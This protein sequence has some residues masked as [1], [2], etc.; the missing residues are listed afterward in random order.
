[1]L[2]GYLL[3]MLAAIGYG[4]LPI[5]VKW[6][7]NL[8]LTMD[9]MLFS[10]FFI[11]SSIMTF[12]LL[13][14]RKKG[15]KRSKSGYFLL[16]LQGLLFFGSSYTYFLSIKYMAATLTNILLYTYP[17]MVVLMSALIYKEKISFVKGLTL[18]IAFFGCLLVV[19][20]VNLS[21]QKISLPGSFYGVLSALFYAIYNI[22]GQYLSEKSDPFTISAS[23]S[24]ICLFANIAIYPPAHVFSG[25]SQMAL[26]IVGVGTAIL[27]TVIPL[28][29][30]QKGLSLLGA[31]RAS[32]LSTVEPAITIVLA[33]L[34]L[35]ETLTNSQ[36]LGGLLIISGVLLL[37]LDNLE[38]PYPLKQHFNS[39]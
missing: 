11:A 30:Y 34:I 1:M 3:I 5:F 38:K 24:I 19:D 22:L 18:L 21:G 17:L 29:C 2:N 14:R 9:L 37:K 36:L 27:C 32:I 31:S 25:H 6:G 20:V 13:A 10:R 16:A 8:G 7:Y 23:T 26:W 35:G 4:S 15:F 33:G 39:H 28:F 12:I